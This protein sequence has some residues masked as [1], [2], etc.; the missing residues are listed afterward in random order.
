MA[1]DVGLDACI[2]GQTL[3]QQGVRGLFKGLGAPLA[4]VA[5]FNAVL[6]ATRGQMENLL[7]HE[8]GAI[9]VWLQAELS[10]PS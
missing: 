5:L 8:D 10:A 2:A 4:T 7:A 6:F 9:T 3:Q 1:P